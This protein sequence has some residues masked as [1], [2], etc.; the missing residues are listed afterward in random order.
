M[1]VLY[2]AHKDGTPPILASYMKKGIIPATDS[3]FFCLDKAN[4]LIM[5]SN[6]LE[7]VQAIMLISWQHPPPLVHNKST[8]DCKSVSS[9]LRYTTP[10][11]KPWPIPRGHNFST[12][13]SPRVWWWWWWTCHQI[14]LSILGGDEIHARMRTS[15]E[16]SMLKYK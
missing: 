11:Y 10:K 14:Y 8:R 6:L 5:T 1:D 4:K 2:A 7:H 9:W 3:K 15:L 12:I 13:L 16:G